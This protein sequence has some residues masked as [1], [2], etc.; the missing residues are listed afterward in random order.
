MEHKSV[1]I[2]DVLTNTIPSRRPVWFMRQAGRYLPEYRKVRNDAGS[3]LSLCFNPKLAAEVTLQPLRR[4]DLDAAI[5]FADILLIPKALGTSLDFL[6]GEGPVLESCT[7]INSV[8]ALRPENVVTQLEPVFEAINLIKKNLPYHTGLI[9][10]CGAPWTVASYMVEGKSTPDRAKTRFAAFNNSE[11][12]NVLIDTLVESSIEYLEQQ[13]KAGVDILQIFDTW[14]GDLSD[15]IRE[16]YCFTPIKKIISGLRGR[17][18]TVP[19]IG[20]AK[21]IG[22][23]LPEF[24]KVTGVNAIGVDWAVPVNWLRNEIPSNVIIQGNLDPLSLISGKQAMAQNVRAILQGLPKSRHIFN[25]G[26][27]IRPETP[28]EHVQELLNLIRK[29]D[30]ELES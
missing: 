30:H 9:G 19:I 10:F 29:I 8:S 25:L 21:G 16:K 12:F 15:G 11:W 22:P 23:A 14:A 13:V 6:E 7:D 28:I 18:V 24:A 1:P 27:G 17:G 3:F 4:F 20:F 26:H 5:L 2:L